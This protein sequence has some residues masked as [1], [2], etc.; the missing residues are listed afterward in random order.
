LVHYIDQ[1]AIRL[2]TAT[3]WFWATFEQVD[4]VSQVIAIS[5]LLGLKR[6]RNIQFSIVWNDTIPALN[7]D[8]GIRGGNRSS[9][10]NCSCTAPT[11]AGIVHGSPSSD[12]RCL[13]LCLNFLFLFATI[14][15]RENY[16]AYQAA[17]GVSGFFQ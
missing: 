2:N 17:K 12:A 7:N 1:F 14:Q 8:N 9:G 10:G 13:P 4:N 15:T 5:F 3:T 11:G 16:G 6:K